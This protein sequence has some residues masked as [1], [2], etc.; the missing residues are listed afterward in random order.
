MIFPRNYSTEDYAIK[1]NAVGSSLSAFT[2]CFFV[3]LKDVTTVSS[4]CLYSY[5]TSE[6]KMGNGIYICFLSA[7]I[8][9]NI[10]DG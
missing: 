5:A 10:A 2:V 9:L 1:A 3:K 8:E 7:E 4:Q 6:S